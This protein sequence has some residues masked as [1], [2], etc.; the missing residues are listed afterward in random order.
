M[1]YRTL[2]IAVVFGLILPFVAKALA[3]PPASAPPAGS[4]SYLEGLDAMEAK[5]WPDAVAALSKSVEADDEKATYHTARGIAEML[6]GDTKAAKEDLDRALRLDRNDETTQRWAAGLYRMTGD[7]NTAARIRS[8]ADY[9]GIQEA[10]EN[11]GRGP[12]HLNSPAEANK[13]KV[14]LEGFAVQYASDMKASHPELTQ[15]LV[16]RMKRNFDAGRFDDALKDLPAIQRAYPLDPV[17]LYY[18]A[19]CLRATGD[20][21]TA[22]EELTRVLTAKTDYAAAYSERAIVNL[23]LGN[24]ARA[25]KDM[26]RCAQYEPADAN[27][28]RPEFEKELAAYKSDPAGADLSV[29]YANLVKAAGSGQSS[30]ELA[31]LA[32]A[33]LQASNAHRKRWDELYQDRLCALE[34]AVRQKPN[35]VPRLMAMGEFLYRE[36]DPG[37]ETEGPGGRYIPFRYNGNDESN[38]EITRADQIFDQVLAL[39]PQNAMAMTWKAAIRLEN[40]NWP[41]GEAWVNKALA[42]RADIPELLELL[43]RVLD[44]SASVKQ[45]QAT[46]LRTP[47]TWYTFG[48]D[49][50]WIHTHNPTDEELSRADRLENSANALWNRAQASLIAAV[51]GKAG[52]ADGFYYDGLLQLRGNDL[53]AAARDFEQAAKM[54]P[55]SK[56]DR[57]ALA[58]AYRKLGRIDDAVR[59]K[60]SFVLSRQ[61]TAVTRLA[62]AWTEIDRTATRSARATLDGAAGIDP[63]D[64]RIP[65]YE[66]SLATIEKKPADAVKWYNVALA[67]EQ[68]RA[69]EHGCS[70][71]EKSR[72]LLDADDVSLTLLMNLRAAARLG[73]MKQ[74][75]LQLKYLQRNFIGSHMTPS[76]REAASTRAVLPNLNDPHPTTPRK[77]INLLAWSHVNAAYLLLAQGQKDEAEKNFE[78]VWKWPHIGDLFEAQQ[79]AC[80]GSLRLR[81]AK[82]DPDQALHS[83]WL[84]SASK[85]RGLSNQECDRVNKI[86]M[87][88]Y[89]PYKDPTRLQRVQ[90]QMMELWKYRDQTA[91]PGGY[92]AR[93]NPNYVG[94]DDRGPDDAP[95]PAANDPRNR[96]QRIP[97]DAAR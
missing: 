9:Q 17:V 56:R 28:M 3:D 55:D 38:R 58:Q 18:H 42:I 16:A 77:T 60:E 27:A 64:S 73:E 41:D 86:L 23:R 80:A 51:R 36:S 81:M 52:T 32:D 83:Q 94:T 40:D 66:A 68:A 70:L 89:D 88:G 63:A 78:M 47:K 67:L 75:D 45:Y 53:E 29:L 35:D 97:D 59:E 10:A 48:I 82:S 96:P 34:D 84:A 54:E 72:R 2:G 46:D 50:T 43:T 7:A 62:Q 71:E 1:P 76:A 65:A 85:R 19:C 12:R 21:T 61:T 39:D 33:L 90:N 26:Q 91:V 30:D 93:N 8:P 44:S 31:P 20:L 5:H 25:R 15:I 37:G 22:R 24:L 6:A 57:D 79:L 49:V 4:E 14:Q 11:A 74:P 13:A 69:V 92:D 87:T 95:T